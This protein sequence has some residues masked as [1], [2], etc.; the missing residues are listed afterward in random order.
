M[1]Q[2]VFSQFLGQAG[3]ARSTVLYPLAWLIGLLLAGLVLLVA[4]ANPAPWI[5]VLL[6][7]VVCVGVAVYLVGWILFAI[8]N[9][10][11]LR[12]ERFT[13]SKMAIEKRLT[14]DTLKGFV[15]TKIVDETV[16]RALPQAT[17]Q[18]DEESA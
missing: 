1:I 5:V 9:P 16:L 15:E 8:H 18:N 12:S 17:P 14:G 3:G 7:V 6:A 11:A 10:D 13:L 4:F 2:A